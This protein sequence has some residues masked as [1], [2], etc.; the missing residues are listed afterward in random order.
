M[1]AT[2][3]SP[4]SPLSFY[5]SGSSAAS[6]P[7]QPVQSLALASPSRVCPRNTECPVCFD[8]LT[9]RRTRSCCHCEQGFHGA[10]MGL[11]LQQRRR[12]CPM[13]RRA[14]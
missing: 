12:T 8:A 1:G 4:I 3:V 7:V 2:A 9:P 11:W 13:C 14:L 10:C 6:T 5:S